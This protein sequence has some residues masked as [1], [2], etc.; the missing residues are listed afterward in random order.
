[1]KEIIHIGIGQAGLNLCCTQLRE[2]IKLL[3]RDLVFSA[4]RVVLLDLDPELRLNVSLKFGD[5]MIDQD[6]MV[7]GN[8]DSANNCFKAHY[9]LG[10]E[11]VEGSIEIIR[12]Q[13]EQCDSL[14]GLVIHS[15]FVGGTGSGL[16]S[17]LQ[18]RL[19]VDLGKVKKV[20]NALYASNK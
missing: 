14:E 20:N 4:P 12:R 1:M 3:P 16:T 8:E 7:K 11:I 13:I 2:I 6:K 15:S 10:K 5:L 18:E 17:L 9:T 19:S